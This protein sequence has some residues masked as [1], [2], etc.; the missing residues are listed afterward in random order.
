MSLPDQLGQE[1]SSW[2]NQHLCSVFSCRGLPNSD[3]EAFSTCVPLGGWSS[4][5]EPAESL[6]EQ[7]G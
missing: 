4:G 3:F 5:R 2:P 7:Y 1:P 6:S